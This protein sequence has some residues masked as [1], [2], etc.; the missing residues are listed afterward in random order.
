MCTTYVCVVYLGGIIY[1]LLITFIIIH[2]SFPSLCENVPNSVEFIE[3]GH[4][5]TYIFAEYTI[6]QTDS[7]MPHCTVLYHAMLCHKSFTFFIC[8][9][10]YLFI[11]IFYSS[12]FSVNRT[13]T[14]NNAIINDDD[15]DNGEGHGK[16]SMSFEFVQSEIMNRKIVYTIKISNKKKRHTVKAKT[17]KPNKTSLNGMKQRKINPLHGWTTKRAKPSK[18]A[19]KLTSSFSSLKWSHCGY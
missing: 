11:C 9:F 1:L 4:V 15:N 7:H 14:T 5:Y 6:I 8:L 2:V 10:V 12:F 13:A 3:Q 19:A 18:I 16:Q 17:T